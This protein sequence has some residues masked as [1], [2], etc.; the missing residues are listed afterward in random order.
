MICIKCGAEAL[1]N[2]IRG[3]DGKVCRIIRTCPACE[4]IETIERG[5]KEREQ[6][7]AAIDSGVCP[8]S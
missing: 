3:P 8:L 4:H 6:G 2:A 5:R 1:E 7:Q